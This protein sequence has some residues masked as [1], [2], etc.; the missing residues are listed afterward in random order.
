[1]M[2]KPF[3]RHVPDAVREKWEREDEATLS[4]PKCG[5]KFFIQLEARRYAKELPP[6]HL[7]PTA[8]PFATPPLALGQ[9]LPTIT[10]ASFP[11]YICVAKDCGTIV[12][13][14]IVGGE[15]MGPRQWSL[16]QELCESIE[17]KKDTPPE[18]L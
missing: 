7:G 17:G 15:E 14:T 1:M 11:V 5:G 9:Q 12:T 6:S 10:T 8:T 4:C 3:T 13:P 16:Y 18:T 2:D